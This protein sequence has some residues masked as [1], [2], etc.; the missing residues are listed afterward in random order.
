MHKILSI[1]GSD[2]SGGAGIQADLKTF[3][4]LK[5]YGM[6]VITALTAQNT[7]CVNASFNVPATFVKKQIETLFQDIKPDCIKIGMLP[8]SE[9]IDIVRDLLSQY[10][11]IP[12]VL[13]PVMVSTSGDRLI[14]DE[15][16]KKIYCDLLPIV[17]LVTPNLHEAQVFTGIKVTSR[18]DLTK[19]AM[20]LR[21][22]APTTNILI[23]G[24]HLN[25]ACDLLLYDSQKQ[26][27]CSDYIKTKNTHG[28]GCT[29]SSA[30]AC[31]LAHKQDIL[32]A[33]R[34]AKNYLYNSIY[35]GQNLRI[36]HGN[37]PVNHLWE[38]QKA[39]L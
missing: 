23:K 16:I 21:E 36:G 31:K 19:A 25:E 28:T 3:S 18:A 37:G 39:I 4:A 33:C 12:T 34:S 14:D 7:Q 29:L 35:H 27:L 10:T 17:T 24:G 9:I 1:A 5:C 11:E 20:K 30:I 13:D 6:S 22:S 15:A 32:T 26:W 38:I 8:N 2:P